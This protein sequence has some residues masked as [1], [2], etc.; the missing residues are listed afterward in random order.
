M[1]KIIDLSGQRF[2]SLTAVGLAKK[3]GSQGETLWNCLCD[4]GKTAIGP[5]A[6]LRNGVKHRCSQHCIISST[7]YINLAGQKFGELTALYP[8]CRIQHRREGWAWSCVCSCGRKNVDIAA[9]QLRH[10]GMKYCSKQCL[11]RPYK[12]NF[13]LLYGQR[14]GKL[15]AI[16]PC[17]KIDS[18]KRDI[19]WSCQCDCGKQVVAAASHLKSGK[20]VS[21]KCDWSIRARYLNY[22]HG[23]SNHVL[24]GLWGLMIYRCDSPNHSSYH[25]YGGRG[26]DVCDRWREDFLAFAADM[27]VRPSRKHSIDRIDNDG[28]YEPSNCRW[29]TQRQQSRNSRRNHWQTIDGTTLCLT[30]W[31]NLYDMHP[32]TV[33]SRARRGWSFEEALF[34]PP[35]ASR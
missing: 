20:I 7:Q 21:C 25:N 15:V 28:N 34:V 31:C 10:G 11:S 17:K 8:C 22:K 23:Y 14:F 26:I 18:K 3:K 4:C 5:T 19:Y 6:K 1:R 30:D 33:R 13:E 24:Y 35:G 2:G 12:P 27:G 9:I 32:A 16:A 29:A